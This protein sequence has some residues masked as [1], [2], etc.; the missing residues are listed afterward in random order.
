VPPSVW[1]MGLELFWIPAAIVA[2][3]RGRM[4]AAAPADSPAPATGDPLERF[5]ARLRF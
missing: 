1:R 2:A 5:A 3:I 4:L